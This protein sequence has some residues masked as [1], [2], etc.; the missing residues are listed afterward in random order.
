MAKREKKLERGIESLKKQ[1]KIHE[2]KVKEDLI[3]GNEER[4]RYHE[5]ELESLRRRIK[6]RQEKLHRKK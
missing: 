4:A 5:T 6:D 3:K 1:E 2:E